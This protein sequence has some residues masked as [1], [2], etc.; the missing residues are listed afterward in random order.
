MM[1]RRGAL[2]MF[3]KSMVAGAG[4]LH[5]DLTRTPFFNIVGSITPAVQ[6]ETSSTFEAQLQADMTR[7][8]TRVYSEEGIAMIL[9]CEDL[10]AKKPVGPSDKAMDA[11]VSSAFHRYE[12]AWQRLHPEAPAE[13]VAKLVELLSY[14]DFAGGGKDTNL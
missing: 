6:P 7:L 9:A 11:A 4:W 12:E 1:N 2:A 13:D 5:F 14:R 10:T 3:G 8:G